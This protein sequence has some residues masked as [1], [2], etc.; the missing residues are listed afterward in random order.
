MN[1]LQELA[2]L[3]PFLEVNRCSAIGVDPP[4]DGEEVKFVGEVPVL[5]EESP[6]VHSIDRAAVI[7]IN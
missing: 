2:V 4:D 1:R 7:L 3:A 6:E 5:S